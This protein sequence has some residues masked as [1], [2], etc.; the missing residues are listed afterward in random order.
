[1]KTLRQTLLSTCVLGWIASGSSV[2]AQAGPASVSAH[3]LASAETPSTA[4]GAVAPD[5]TSQ[6]I[7]VTAQRR[8]ESLS[9]TPVAVSVIS[10]ETLAKLGFSSQS[11]LHTA[12]PGLLIKASQ[13]SN[14]LN[15]SIRGQSLEPFSS[16]R[17]GVLP[18][19]NEVQVGGEGANSLYDLQSVQVL[20]GPQGTLFGRNATGGAVL[21][22]STRPTDKFG[23]YI[24]GRLGDYSLRQVEGAIN[25]PIMGDKLMARIAGD[26]EY[27]N[28]F[29]RNLFDGNRVGNVR[30]QA[31]RGSLTFAPNNAFKN[32]LVVDYL[33]SGGSGTSA[34]I[35]FITPQG[36]S[37]P[38]ASPANILFSP[39]VDSFFG[40][41]TWN[42][43]LALHPNVDPAGIVAFAAKQ[44]ARGPF[45]IDVDSGGGHQTHDLVITNVSTLDVGQ[46]TKIKNIFGYTHLHSVDIGEFDGT[47][48]GIDRAGPRGRNVSTRQYSDEL[49]LV[50]N[51]F[52]DRLS[53]VTG[54]YYANELVN[55]VSQSIVF[56]LS[57]IFGP[58]E[59]INSAKNRSKTYA[60]Y[61]QGTYNLDDLT[62]IHGLSFTAG[63]RY[64]SEKISL[65]RNPDDLYV[66][67][68]KPIFNYNLQDTFKKV[69]WQFGLQEQVDPNLLLYVVT[70]RSF[71]S[72]GFNFYA[73]PLNGF[74][75][76]LGAEY[77]PQIVT[78]VEAGA[79]F[80]GRLEDMPF[81][82]NLAVYNLWLTDNQNVTYLN[83]NGVASAVT[84]NVPKAKV[85][86]FE[87]DA[88]LSP[89]SF[90]NVGSTLNYTNARY[91]KNLVSVLGSAPI[92][93]GP[94]TDTPKWSGSVYAEVTVPISGDWKASFRGDG[95]VQSSTVFSSTQSTLNPGA[96]I[97]GYAIADFR[98]AVENS[99]Q[100]WSLSANLKNAFNQTYYV[101][102][103][104]FESVFTLDA[105][106]PGDPR[107]FFVQLRKTF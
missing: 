85:Y 91:T 64:T 32:E 36:Q 31:V 86:G 20:K 68:P 62:G 67:A 89:T 30:R 60:V 28:G 46:D 37:G 88:V 45:L 24:S 79:K 104:A 97:S 83:I 94:Y 105:L 72:G 5:S 92:A 47:P 15:F 56:D 10:G 80:S 71:R 41:G 22:T 44:K 1:M 2:N 84:I 101:G 29:Q 82:A 53:Y 3:A 59:L 9:K 19:L 35:S 18:Y 58:F 33:H 40:P 16:I 87:L 73:P 93:F 96:V 38:N 98:V 13:S 6:D 81:R 12:V 8:S 50:G 11:D 102:G 99:R 4:Q 39:Q 42:R 90:I 78:D 21:F 7:V 69:S 100:G 52:G 17:P 76:Q 66:L 74:G 61:G 27:R 49:Q 43:Y 63:A 23:G 25:I 26:Y 95:V 103:L 106:V 107:T 48:F 54:L 70:R 57:P 34:V 14:Q 75:A 55:N 65:T 77:K 51:A